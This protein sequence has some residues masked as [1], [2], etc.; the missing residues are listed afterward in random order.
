MKDIK[1]EEFMCNTVYHENAISHAYEKGMGWNAMNVFMQPESWEILAE[2]IFNGEYETKP[3]VIHYLD[4]NNG[5]SINYEQAVKVDFENVRE[6]YVMDKLDRVVWNTFYQIYYEKYNHLIHENCVSYKRKVSTGKVVKE[7]SRKMNELKYYKGYKIDI[8][9]FFD[10][11]NRETLFKTLDEISDNSK[12]DQVVKRFFNDDRVI[13]NGEDV[14]RYKSLAQGCAMGCL[15]ADLCLR[16]IDEVLSNMDII[17]YRY[18]DDIIMLGKDSTKA[19]YTLNL[20]LK[21]KGLELNPKKI[22]YLNAEN[23]WF[24]FLGFKL[25]KD[26]ITMSSKKVKSIKNKIKEITITYARTVKRPCTKTEIKRMISQI[27]WYFFTAFEQSKENFGVGNYLFATVNVDI[28][29]ERIETYIRDCLRACYTGKKEIY[30]IGS[31]NDRKDYTI[32]FVTGKNVSMNY[33]KTHNDSFVGGDLLIECGWY[34]LTH[35]KKCFFNGH[36]VYQ[37]EVRKIANRIPIKLAI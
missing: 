10:K 2:K 14:N 8:S 13:I 33:I 12:I 24:D 15:L 1:L 25:K 30:G 28:D 36:S 9:K 31:T 16:D 32:P 6:L 29:I 18:S 34:S 20:M 37:G 35:M 7:L 23:E 5:N 17:Y 21:D 4:K 11:V 22:E 3:P 19:M 26:L 27:Q